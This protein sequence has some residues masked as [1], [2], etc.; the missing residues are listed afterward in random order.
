M[1]VCVH[2]NVSKCICECV[3]MCVCVCECAYMCEGVYVCVDAYMH[4][5]NKPAKSI[6]SI[7]LVAFWIVCGHD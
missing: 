6:T 7:T 5:L 1:F 2:V 4:L 3:H